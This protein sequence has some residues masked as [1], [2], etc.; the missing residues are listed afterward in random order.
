MGIP[1]WCKIPGQTSPRSCEYRRNIAVIARLKN[2]VTPSVGEFVHDTRAWRQ[3]E[4]PEVAAA[5]QLGGHQK[6]HEPEALRPVPTGE[7][8]LESESSWAI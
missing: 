5:I 8:A 2:E 3:G 7:G 6:S 4:S 1:N